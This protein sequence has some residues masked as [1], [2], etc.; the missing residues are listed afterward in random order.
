MICRGSE[1]QGNHDT[2]CDAVSTFFVNAEKRRAPLIGPLKGQLP[3]GISGCS[4]VAF[5]FQSPGLLHEVV[6][7]E[8]SVG[9][10]GLCPQGATFRGKV[11]I[12]HLA[13]DDAPTDMIGK[14]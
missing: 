5:M 12:I 13:Y 1:L 14:R 10:P 8:T 4:A 2:F 7:Y 3:D 11:E 9:P 6:L